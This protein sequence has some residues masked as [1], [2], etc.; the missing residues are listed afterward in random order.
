M[1]LMALPGC[2]RWMRRQKSLW[3]QTPPAW[4]PNISAAIARRGV[5]RVSVGVQSLDE[6]Q[7]NA[8]G[9]QH[10]PEEALAAFRLA[11]RIFPR[12][13]FDM[14]YARP[15]QT[16]AD[17]RSELGRALAEQQGHM[18]LYQLTIEPETRFADLHAAGKLE[19][20]EDD[21]AADLYDLTQELTE[22]AGLPAYE[23]SNHARPGDESRHNLLYWRY[24]EYAGAGPGAHSRLIDGGNRVALITEKHPETWRGLVQSRGHGMV[25][26]ETLRKAGEQHGG[27]AQHIFHT[28]R[29]VGGFHL[30]IN[31]GP[32]I[33]ADRPHFEKRIHKE[34]QANLGGHPA[35]GGVG[36]MDEAR[37]LQIHHHVAHRGGR[38][39]NMRGF[40]MTC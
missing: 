27:L 19:L 38:E 36:R 8:L 22:Q 18:S 7:L 21:L 10:T 9:R 40:V 25:S 12:V 15:G 24:G 31:A 2:G 5:N 37:I 30:G 16:L 34:A 23:V 26:D 35:C 6:E 1:C 33:L 32:F 20:P 13:S 14:I 39:G 11:A 4:R 17:W 3:K 28:A 29:T